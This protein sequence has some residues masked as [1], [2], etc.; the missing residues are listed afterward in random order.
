MPVPLPI[1]RPGLVFR[2]GCRAALLLA[3]AV[4]LHG[5]RVTIRP[6][7]TEDA[8]GV[9]VEYWSEGRR[10]GRS[11]SEA[12]AGV[13]LRLPG[14]EPAPVVFRKV[15]RR[16]DGLDLG[17]VEV[18]GFTLRWRL[19]QRNPS[20]V[21]RTLEVT[22][23]RGGRFA[24]TFPLDVDVP[25]ELASFTGAERE[26]ALY[27]T[28]VRERRNQTFPVAWVRTPG[29]VF[30]VIADSPGY[31]ENRCEVRVDPAA[32]QVA[33][34]A[35][36]GEAPFRM[37][38]QPPED[39]RDTYRYDMDG[40]QALATGETRRFTTWV[41]ASP[42]RHHYDAQVAFQLAVANAKGW[43]GSALEGLLRNT[44][45]YLL[46]RNLMRDAQDRPRDGRYIFISGMSYG[47][48][49]WVSTGL[50]SALGLDDPEAMVEAQRAVF[51]NRMDYEDNAQ[52]YL[53]WAALARRA[54]GEV[55]VA[56]ARRALDFIR[57]H[58]QDG[59]YVPPPL[60]GAPN[61]KGWK[62]YMDVLPYDDDDS[63]TSNQG[64]HC[65]A[66]LAARELGLPV[67]ERAIE[68][69]IAAYQRL[70]NARRR[71]FPTSRKQSETL[72]QDTL[73]GATL[74]YAAFGRKLLTDDQVVG[75]YRTSEAVRSPFGLRV[76]SQADGSLLPGHDGS[77]CHG[78]SW[79]FCDSGNYLLAGVHGVPASEVDARLV[80]R[81]GLELA[82]V[83]AFHEDI[84]TETGK[85]HG[86]TPYAD[87]S[88]YV[89]L[90]AEIRRRLGQTGPDPVGRAIDARLGVVREGGVLA[91]DPGRAGT[92]DRPEA[93]PRRDRRVLYNFDGDS[94]LTTK[95]GGKGPVA[96][97][98]ADVRR[99]IDEVAGPGSR[100]DTVLVCVNAQAMYYPTRVGTL[101]GT[102]STPEERSRWPA[103]EVQ[104]F[105][106][107]QAFF[108]AGIDPYA[109][110]LAEARRRG[111]E[112]FLTFRMNDD[113]GNDF[114]RT[115]F[116]VEHPEWRVGTEP[117]QGRDALDFGREEVRDYTARL[118]EEAVRR[119]DCD[120]LELDFNRFPRFFKDGTTEE[121]V[122]KM[123]ALVER[124][125]AM[126]DV[127]GRERGQRLLLSV[128][129][130]SNYGRTPPTP[131]TARQLGCDVPGWVRRGWLDFVTVSEFLHERGDLPIAEWRRALPGVPV[132]GGIECTR[133][134]GR[135]N[136][137][138]DEYRSAADRLRREGAAGVY[139]F[140]FFTSR[141]EG[142]NAYE[143][144]FEVLG[145]LGAALP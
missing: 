64:F 53:I 99:L 26:R 62:S 35:G 44:S 75:H 34:L 56:L 114:L 69:A 84:H 42:A 123:D 1:P 132:Y 7:V 33:V 112:A 32:R 55:D 39:A 101:R 92:E 138:A 107:L 71:F 118:I 43:N 143:P 126:L 134:G 5:A 111:R 18:G 115:R 129:V 45:L 20:L 21:E 83:P 6:V 67:D 10:V 78:G 28:G 116:K 127:V 27:H 46:R 102:L 73:Y 31:W 136:L 142:A 14:A 135:R 61:P 40:W 9:R 125:R 90:R 140:N 121:R 87:Y 91:L 22:A 59:L 82:D 4:G 85:P 80:E 76:I 12:P 19:R 58:E 41:F 122:A 57:G 103:S 128:R 88:A 54:G 106:N 51:W 81:I 133:G 105:R 38:I 86:N 17:P 65:G 52:Y 50:Y 137:T 16:D 30:G 60:P 144:P 130:P 119:Y 49:Q 77:Y 11:T 109:V 37:V 117:Y 15:T 120:G 100:V 23:S 72:G 95:A 3:T 124:V 25:G 97:G 110:M 2:L 70:Y 47:W 36:D 96:V 145:D 79:F 139:L 89:W 63:P 66:L 24:A 94:C 113:H 48:K 98:V 141:E 93:P 104:R 29:E 68:A 108:D 131:E 74:T 8:G 13:A